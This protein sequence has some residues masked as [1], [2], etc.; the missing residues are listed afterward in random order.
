MA[1][2]KQIRSSFIH[3]IPTT[4]SSAKGKPSNPLL[5][6]TCLIS[7]YFVPC[8]SSASNIPNVLVE[9]SEPKSY[10]KS[11]E[12]QLLIQ[13]LFEIGMKNLDHFFTDDVVEDQFL[14]QT[15]A[16]F[17]YSW[18]AFNSLRAT[19]DLS[20]KKNRKSLLKDNLHDIDLLCNEL[21][22]LIKQCLDRKKSTSMNLSML[23][24]TYMEKLEVVK[25]IIAKVGQIKAKVSDHSLVF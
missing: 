3:H 5:V 11:N 6:S 4:I 9:L 14:M 8:Q 15:L 19:Y 21:V 18:N 22:N 10:P 12:H 7:S 25:E 17:A 1:P 20:S 23:S 13:S 24:Q 16:S 2:A